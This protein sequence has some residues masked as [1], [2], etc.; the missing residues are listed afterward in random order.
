MDFQGFNTETAH[1]LVL[2]IVVSINAFRK[3]YIMCLLVERKSADFATNGQQRRTSNKMRGSRGEIWNLLENHKNIWFLSNTGLYP[4]INHKATKSS[5]NVGPP[6]ARHRSAIKMAFRR[7][8][9]DGPLLVLIGSSLP[10][11]STKRE[12]KLVRIGLTLA[13]RSGSAHDQD[14]KNCAS[15]VNFQ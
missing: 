12:K 2:K 15:C 9:D 6:S 10:S 7:R 1:Y 3:S 5:F 14:V 4:L 11:S 8:A 13:K